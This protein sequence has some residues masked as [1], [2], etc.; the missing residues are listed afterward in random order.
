MSNEL[1][2]KTEL[3]R[4]LDYLVK[5]L[6]VNDYNILYNAITC[7]TET[8]L[9]RL[10]RMDE[11]KRLQRPSEP[12]YKQLAEKL[13]EY[14][15]LLGDELNRTAVYLNIHNMGASK[16]AIAKG[17]KLKAEIGALKVIC[18]EVKK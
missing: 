16:E 15:H 5:E 4:I 3:N 13:D 1:K 17:E 2:A 18:D 11:V 10:N 8:T 14:A 7:T 6:P 12:N 9:Q